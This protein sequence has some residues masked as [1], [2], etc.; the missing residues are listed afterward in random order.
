MIDLDLQCTSASHSEEMLPVHAR[1]DVM[2]LVP[3]HE[4]R[5]HECCR[6][7]QTILSRDSGC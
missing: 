6:K 4:L 3:W 5:N 7:T 1:A 2:D